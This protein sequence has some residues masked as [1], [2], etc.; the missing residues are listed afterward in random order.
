M[1]GPIKSRRS[2]L[3]A[4][5]ASG[6]RAAALPRLLTRPVPKDLRTAVGG[7][8]TGR[9][10]TR[11]V[12]ATLAVRTG[13]GYSDNVLAVEHRRPSNAGHELDCVNPRFL[14][15]LLYN[16]FLHHRRGM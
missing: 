9:F 14:A 12:G 10:A 16:A 1:Q 4:A 11:R 13:F 15:I 8:E 7:P 5:G 6:P 3:R 2:T